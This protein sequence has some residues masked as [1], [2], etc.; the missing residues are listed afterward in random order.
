MSYGW[1]T[2]KERNKDDFEDDTRG[3]NRMRDQRCEEN[4]IR[5]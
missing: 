4:E 3:K 2:E 1:K 5:G